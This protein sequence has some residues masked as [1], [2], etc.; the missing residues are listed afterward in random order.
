MLKAKKLFVYY[1]APLKFYI[2]AALILIDL[3]K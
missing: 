3:T 2:F 1:L